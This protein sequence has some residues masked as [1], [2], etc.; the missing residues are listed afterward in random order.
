MEDRN[1]F[2]LQRLWFRA[3]PNMPTYIYAFMLLAKA[4]PHFKAFAIVETAMCL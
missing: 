1:N 2:L 4:L 3:L